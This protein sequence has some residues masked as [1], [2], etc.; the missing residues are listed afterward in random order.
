MFRINS[1]TKNDGLDIEYFKNLYKAP[2]VCES[3]SMGQ[4]KVTNDDVLLLSGEGQINVVKIDGL[5]LVKKIIV[6]KKKYSIE[7]TDKYDLI[8]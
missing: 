2:F 1:C 3:M 6:P 8:S 7:K 4:L 5:E